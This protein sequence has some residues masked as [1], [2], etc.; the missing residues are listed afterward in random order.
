MI[1]DGMSTRREFFQRAAL[2]TAIQRAFAIDPPKGST[3]ED[4]EHIVVLMQENRSFDHAL[5]AL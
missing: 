4:A 2:F 1:I 3:F 5:G